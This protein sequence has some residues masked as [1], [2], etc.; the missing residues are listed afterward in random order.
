MAAAIVPVAPVDQGEGF[1]R[2]CAGDSSSEPLSVARW[3]ISEEHRRDV[4]QLLSMITQYLCDTVIIVIAVVKSVEMVLHAPFGA[5]NADSVLLRVVRAILDVS[6]LSGSVALG[7]RDQRGMEEPKKRGG[8]GLSKKSLPT[9]SSVSSKSSTSAKSDAAERKKRK[10]KAASVEAEAVAKPSPVLGMEQQAALKLSGTAP[11]T[12][13]GA[14]QP[15]DSGMPVEPVQPV[16]S[17]GWLPLALVIIVTPLLSLLIPL[18]HYLFSRDTTPP[19]TIAFC[20]TPDCA[21]FGHEVSLAI[22]AAIDPCHDFHGF[23]CGGWKES[24][25]RPSTEARMITDAYDM[26]IKEVKNDA[27]RASKTTQFF[28]SCMSAGKAQK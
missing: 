2:F 18:L 27:Q 26:A 10:Q 1:C 25:L 14:A 9:K 11:Q 3:L 6:A 21:A 5:G 12:P 19:K 24:T 28:G 16:G 20:S 8:T 15:V 23:V 17:L 13:A 4:F 7:D 22:N